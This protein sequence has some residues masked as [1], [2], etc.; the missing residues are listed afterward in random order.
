MVER[1]D[2]TVSAYSGLHAY[3]RTRVRS[4]TLRLCACAFVRRFWHL[5]DTSGSR[6]AIE[7]SEQYADGLVRRKEL[8]SARAG[9]P[10]RASDPA[11]DWVAKAAARCAA[12]G[13]YWR[14]V[15]DIAEALLDTA[16]YTRSSAKAE[17]EAQCEIVQHL[18]NAPSRTFELT[19]S[20]SVLQLA[21]ALY[22]GE[23]CSFALHDALLEVGHAD[24]AEHFREPYHPKGCWALDL[25]LGKQKT[26]R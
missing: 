4:R 9:T 16:R 11:V 7:V 19:F 20:P 13:V 22:S 10:A 21:N 25:L 23:A 3:T 5:L 15:L 17:L 14:D 26:R 24:L 2:Y 8:A 6:R 1:Q 18:V 12:S